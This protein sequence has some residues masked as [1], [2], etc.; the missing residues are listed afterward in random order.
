M[1]LVNDLE[2]VLLLLLQFPNVLTFKDDSYQVFYRI[3]DNFKMNIKESTYMYH[4]TTFRSIQM[5]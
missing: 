5:E 4:F 2:G 3:L 1:I